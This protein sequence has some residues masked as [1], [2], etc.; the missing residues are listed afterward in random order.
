MS[1]G[2]T[3]LQ[4]RIQ[5][6]H[7]LPSQNYAKQLQQQQLRCH[8]HQDTASHKCR[9]AAAFQYP[10]SDLHQGQALCNETCAVLVKLGRTPSCGS[11]IEEFVAWERSVCNPEVGTF[12]LRVKQ[13]IRRLVDIG[14]FVGGVSVDG[15]DWWFREHGNWPRIVKLSP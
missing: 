8:D 12:A 5:H 10:W 4:P 3:Q 14:V 13:M 11:K 2:T 15:L 7:H 6:N 1:V 9:L